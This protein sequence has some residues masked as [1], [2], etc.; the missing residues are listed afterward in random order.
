MSSRE[1]KSSKQ[2]GFLINTK[3]CNGCKTCEIAC[4]MERHLPIGLRWRQVRRFE[5]GD[6]TPIPVGI[7]VSMS[8]NHCAKP[9]CVEICPENAYTKMPMGQVVHD[10]SVCIGCTKCV[11]ACPYTAPAYDPDRKLTGKCDMCYGRVEAGLQPYCVQCCPNGA[12]KVD[13]MANLVAAY[14]T[15]KDIS[16]YDDGKVVP[17][18]ASSANNLLSTNPSIVIKV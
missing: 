14:G 4:K 18:G 17:S 6:A 5:N 3:Y 11:A 15:R 12:L 16:D 8:C 9:Q 13:I 7:S 1:L 2:L 10:E